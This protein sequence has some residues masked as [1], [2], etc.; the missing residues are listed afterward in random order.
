MEFSLKGSK[1]S[2]SQRK[3][4][5]SNCTTL[6][7][8][9]KSLSSNPF[10]TSSTLGTPSI[11]QNKGFLNKFPISTLSHR[12]TLQIFHQKPFRKSLKIRQQ[13]LKTYFSTINLQ[14]RQLT[15]KIFTTRVKNIDPKVENTDYLSGRYSPSKH[16]F[17]HNLIGELQLPRKFFTTAAQDKFAELNTNTPTKINDKE[18]IIKNKPVTSQNLK[19]SHNL[20][21]KER[22]RRVMSCIKH[23]SSLK[24]DPMILTKIHEI[25]PGIPYGIGNTREFLTAC[26]EG[27]NEKVTLMLESNKWLA[28]TFDG[29]GQC[30]LHWAVRR[31]HV[32]T[33]KI[34]LAAGTWIDSLDYVG[35]SPLFLAVRGE[36]L[37]MIDFLLSNKANFCV[38]TRAGTRI[39]EGV[40]R[41]EVKNL[42]CKHLKKLGF[43]ESDN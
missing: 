5:Y 2:Q 11:Y 31:G 41:T 43:M 8:P 22:Y 19:K 4:V 26:K 40:T 9:L 42:F 10:K 18:P 23:Y 34:L 39:F 15:N 32:K 12:A 20:K 25:L 29:S 38:K 17:T 13:Q 21:I 36:N 28:H 14:Q 1:T 16:K 27:N 37:E 33:V 3:S 35:R 6:K 7:N 24:I 30:A